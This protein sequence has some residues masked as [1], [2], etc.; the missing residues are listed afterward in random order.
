MRKVK[1]KLTQCFSVVRAVGDEGCLEGECDEHGCEVIVGY[2]DKDISREEDRREIFFPFPMF[3]PCRQIPSSVAPLAPLHLLTHSFL[4]EGDWGSR[5]Q[6]LNMYSI[7]LYF[8]VTTVNRQGTL[9]NLFQ[10]QNGL[11]W[12]R[13]SIRKAIFTT[14]SHIFQLQLY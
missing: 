8:G 2:L 13:S 4:Y 9:P 6:K 14:R 11:K 7:A 12:T 10:F 5:E 1:S 3:P